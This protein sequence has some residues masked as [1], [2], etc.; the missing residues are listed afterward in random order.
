MIL[1]ACN[2][3]ALGAILSIVKRAMLLIQII[4][5]I[6]LIIWG[7]I[8]FISMVND[9]DQKNGLKKNILNK[10][11]AAAIVFM[12][13]V[14]VN[15]VMGMVGENTSVSSCWNQANERSNSN[16]TYI[17]P[18]DK[19]QKSKITP[20]AD[21]YEKG[22]KQSTNENSNEEATVPPT[23]PNID[24]SG[25]VVF[26]G[27]SRTVQMYAY[28]S[29]D[30]K[31]ANYSS[32]GVHLV[33]DSIFVAQGGKGLTWMKQTGVPVAEKYFKSDTAIVFWMGVNDLRNIDSYISYMNE[34]VSSW[35][36]NGSRVYYASIGPC[37]GK[38]SSMNDGIAK[39]NTKLQSNLDRNITWIDVYGYL[40]REGYDTSDGLHYTKNTSNRIYNY[41]KSMV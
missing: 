36:K 17:N 41:I 1:N 10:F 5:P 33:G 16:S 15:A 20:N 12:I 13:P 31:G 34:N 38:Y 23:A 32:G 6:L 37:S 9:P 7:S 11:L 14:F 40:N 26:I 35:T 30:W 29:G 27:D 4:V 19:E 2:S 25:K 8:G 24:G 28:I 21:D 22:K 3:P 18:Y 39:F